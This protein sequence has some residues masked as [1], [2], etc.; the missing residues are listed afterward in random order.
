MT[1]NCTAT[2]FFTNYGTEQDQ[3]Q[4][5][6]AETRRRTNN[7]SLPGVE[8]PTLLCNHLKIHF[9]GMGVYQ[10]LTAQASLPLR[11]GIV[12]S[13]PAASFPHI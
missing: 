12:C 7:H 8:E 10:A 6:S 2:S 11:S 4:L 3:P 9:D 1:R 13:L 5:S